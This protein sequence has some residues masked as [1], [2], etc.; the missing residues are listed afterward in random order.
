MLSTLWRCIIRSENEI[1][2]DEEMAIKVC[3]FLVENYEQILSVPTQLR[4]E[5]MADVE[6]TE[7]DAIKVCKKTHQEC[8]MLLM[9]PHTWSLCVFRHLL[10]LSE[11]SH[12][13]KSKHSVSASQVKSTSVRCLHNLRWVDYLRYT[14]L[15]PLQCYH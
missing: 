8:A 9:F 15:T 14:F 13:Q 2:L 12:V 5:I 1:E 10:S 11:D 4:D 3:D 6:R 7:Q